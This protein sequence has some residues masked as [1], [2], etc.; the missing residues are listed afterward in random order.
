MMKEMKKRSSFRSRHRRG[1]RGKRFLSTAA[2]FLRGKNDQSS[3]LPRRPRSRAVALR[4]PQ[5]ALSPR[6]ARR[7]AARLGQHFLIHPAIARRIVAVSGASAGDTV[8][9]VGPGKG[10]LTRALLATGARVIAVEADAKLAGELADLFASEI[11]EGRLE[12]LRADIRDALATPLASGLILP[13]AYRVVSNIPYYLTGELIRLL[14]TGA[15]QPQSMTLLVQKEVADRIV[16]NPERSRGARSK[17]ESLLSLSVKAYGEPVYE[18]KV[19]RGAFRPAPKVDS[20]VI[21]VRD[22][23][24]DRFTST[25]EEERFFALIHAGFAHKRK[26]LGGNLRAAGLP[27]A[28]ALDGARAEDVPLADWL[29][30]AR[31]R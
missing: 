14:L 11:A 26:K 24:R 5:K 22:I 17:K 7:K 12:I 29:A 15:N 3:C 30:L 31:A 28:G 27:S 23:S 4:E 21:S 6:P 8:L 25:A 18:F 9:E 19:P 16:G 10:I 13:P 20:A 1:T 2:S